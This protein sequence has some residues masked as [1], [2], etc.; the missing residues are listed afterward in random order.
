M[1]NSDGLISYAQTELLIRSVIIVMA[2]SSSQ[3]AKKILA[4]GVSVDEL[5][6]AAVQEGYGALELQPED[7]LSLEML[8][9]L[10]ED[11]VKLASIV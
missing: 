6:E 5:A 11:Y 3:V 8:C 7:E 1:R 10:A 2:V 4:L 9:D